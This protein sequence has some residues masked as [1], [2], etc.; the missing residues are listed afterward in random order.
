MAPGWPGTPTSSHFAPLEWRDYICQKGLSREKHTIFLGNSGQGGGRQPVGSPTGAPPSGGGPRTASARL[1]VEERLRDPGLDL[2]DPRLGGR[3][4]REELR[5][6]RP[7]AAG[8]PHAHPPDP[9][10]RRAIAR[11]GHIDEAEVVGLRLL[12]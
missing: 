7:T 3:M 9:R 5:R 1:V 11:L 2:A 12:A 4:R 6:A 8:L 10:G